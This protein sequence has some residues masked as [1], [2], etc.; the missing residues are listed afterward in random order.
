MIIIMA[1]RKFCEVTIFFII[2][3]IIIIF[4]FQPKGKTS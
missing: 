2:I 3:I 4:L 1:S